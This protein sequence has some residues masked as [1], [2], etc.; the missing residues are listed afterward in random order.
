[1]SNTGATS[2]TEAS[3]KVGQ[4]VDS[5]IARIRHLATNRQADEELIYDANGGWAP[6][7][8]VRVLNAVADTDAWFEQPCLT[9]E[10]CLSVR[11]HTSQP[12]SLDECMAEYRDVVRAI[13]DRSCEV[14][15]IKIARVGGL[16]R[17]R[18]VRDL[19]LAYD[20]PMMVICMGGSVVNDTMVA[21]MAATL[22]ADRCVGTW[23]CGDMVTVDPHPAAGQGTSTASFPRSPRSVWASNRIPTSSAPPSLSSSS[24]L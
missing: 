4:S 16:T 7:E 15:N 17:A 12:L 8:A 20:I 11:Q 22:P 24:R 3:V 10:E 18:W 21:H 14:V 5:D 6:W 13:N 9:Y 1:M 19:C 23:S 2:A